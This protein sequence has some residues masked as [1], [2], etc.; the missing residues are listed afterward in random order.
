M[1]N[2]YYTPTIE[3]F[4]VGLEFEIFDVIDWTTTIFGNLLINNQGGSYSTN[5]K[6]VKEWIKNKEVRVKYLDKEDIESFGFEQHHR[7]IDLW[8]K[9]KGIYLREDGHHL[10]EIKLQ[11]GLHDQR[12]KITFVYIGGEESVHFEGFIKNKSELTKL[13]KQLK[14]TQNGD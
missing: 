10:T 4:H 8:F 3:E 11:Y 2:K 5:L 9:R 7:G 14:I 12:L 6:D 1:E 13:V